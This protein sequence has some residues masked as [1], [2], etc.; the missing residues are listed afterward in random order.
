MDRTDM[1]I[2]VLALIWVLG[3][4]V[5]FMNYQLGAGE[6]AS[7]PLLTSFMFYLPAIGIL[8]LIAGI[9]LKIV[10]AEFPPKLRAVSKTLIGLPV[11]LLAFLVVSSL[12]YRFGMGGLSYG[13]P[14][15]AILL[16]LAG[17]FAA[18][19]AILA[20]SLRGIKAGKQARK[21]KK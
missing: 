13:P 3:L 21:S 15:I 7:I 20:R 9:I 11:S 19:L 8:L 1:L 10:P 18:W 5:A 4:Y 14:P 12:F 16:M 17:I 6:L 2:V